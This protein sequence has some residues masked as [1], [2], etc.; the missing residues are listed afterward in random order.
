MTIKTQKK[1][2]TRPPTS[3]S[4][5]PKKRLISTTKTRRKLKT[6]KL[7]LAKRSPKA[8]TIKRLLRKVMKAQ[9]R[10]KLMSSNRRKVRE[11]KSHLSQF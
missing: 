8:L 9:I 1:P 6:L 2:C 3:K 7:R 11:T 10:N 4:P 5:G